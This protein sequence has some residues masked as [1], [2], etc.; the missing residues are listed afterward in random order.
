MKTQLYEQGSNPL[1]RFKK[2]DTT[3]TVTPIDQTDKK[4]IPIEDP[5]RNKKKI[6]PPVV[7]K[8][9]V[10]RAGKLVR[11]SRAKK[12]LISPS[13]IRD[14]ELAT[15]RAKI[16]DVQIT[17]AVTGHDR[18]V[19]GTDVDSRHYTG[20]AVDISMINGVTYNSNPKMFTTLGNILAAELRKMGYV[21]Y[22]QKLGKKSLIWQSKDHYNHLHVSNMPMPGLSTQQL[23]IHKYVRQARR[24]LYDMITKSPE[25]YFRNFK[26]F[27]LWIGSGRRIGTDDEEGASEYLK[28]TWESYW[29]TGSLTYDLRQAM[30]KAHPH[31]QANIK[32]L[33]ELV[34]L[35]AKKIKA[36]KSG[37]WKITFWDYDTS[38]KKW[39]QVK[40]SYIWD[41]M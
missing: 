41:Y 3:N 7:E 13:L 25:L 34:D 2:K 19:D 32:Y 38:T 35:I 28:K 30:K 1:D 36:G 24:E 29:G 31:D 23:A 16:G 12:D 39:K 18:K 37:E 10:N 27:T 33:F 4:I 9:P 40:R 17:F 5:D 15:K 21:P 20:D 8:N 26:A 6:Q 22:E 11:A 14:L